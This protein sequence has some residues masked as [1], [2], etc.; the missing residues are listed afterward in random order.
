MKLRDLLFDYTPVLS[1]YLRQG[2]LQ[3]AEKEIINLK[4]LQV[5]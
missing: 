2:Y 4:E 5:D 3:K 1:R